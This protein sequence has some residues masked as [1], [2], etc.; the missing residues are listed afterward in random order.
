MSSNNNLTFFFFSF[1]SFYFFFDSNC[2][3]IQWFATDI[4]V[5]V[6]NA[7]SW[8][9]WWL[10]C[11]AIDMTINF[12]LCTFAN[13]G[14]STEQSSFW[15]WWLFRFYLFSIVA[16]VW[17]VAGN[18][19]RFYTTTKTTKKTPT[20]KTVNEFEISVFFFSVSDQFNLIRSVFIDI[21]RRFF[22]LCLYK[23]W[24]FFPDSHRH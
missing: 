3:F 7:T 8:S 16:F 1:V 10:F 12:I 19:A 6:L 5:Y 9:C 22:G 23:N 15:S 2:S 24:I 17:I 11:R 4:C 20:T 13:C 14:V 18:F 21:N